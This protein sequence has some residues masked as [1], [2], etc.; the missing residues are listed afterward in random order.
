LKNF[1]IE[2]NHIKYSM[3]GNREKR[4]KGKGKKKKEETEN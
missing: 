3:L 4:K 1:E 2:N